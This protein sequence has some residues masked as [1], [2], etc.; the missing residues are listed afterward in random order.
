M[1]QL[2]QFLNSLV[3]T[4]PADQV[5]HVKNPSMQTMV[6]YHKAV[7]GMTYAVE[8]LKHLR[9]DLKDLHRLNNIV[10][11]TGLPKALAAF[12]NHNGSIQNIVKTFP[13]TESLDDLGYR[14]NDVRS[15]RVVAG[16][17]HILAT[18]SLA[19]TEGMRDVIMRL[20][21]VLDV[22]QDV[23]DERED[24]AEAVADTIDGM[25]EDAVVDMSQ[26][27]TA[28][29]AEQ[30]KE[31]LEALL[32]AVSDLSDVPDFDTEE[33]VSTVTEKVNGTVDKLK[34]IVGL[35]AGDVVSVNPAGVA[36]GY[37][38]TEGTLE[39]LGYTADVVASL[40]RQ[41]ASLVDAVENILDQKDAIVE[42]LI[43]SFCGEVTNKGE[44]GDSTNLDDDTSVPADPPENG[45]EPATEEDDPAD[46]E[47]EEDTS[48]DDDDGTDPAGEEEDPEDEDT[49]SNCDIAC[50]YITVLTA[51]VDASM[52]LVAEISSIGAL[53]LEGATAADPEDEEGDSEDKD[54]SDTEGDDT[55][56]EDTVDDDDTDTAAS[57]AIHAWLNG[58]A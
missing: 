32:L 49:P 21:T 20:K 16:I 50:S 14:S 19:T 28:L 6:R 26:S 4:D 42:S 27:V 25:S 36:E 15:K 54:S 56:E 41:V 53:F 43:S 44:N 22:T 39:S 1:D 7:T 35:K 2:A 24:R 12:V 37:T 46:E 57:E 55:F 48:S 5:A 17:E 34:T 18:E 33:G 10:Q 31:V 52:A 3:T 45:G 51:S 30:F 11:T 13:A 23:V 58:D 47:E 38:A 29:S 8:N 40:L 9:K